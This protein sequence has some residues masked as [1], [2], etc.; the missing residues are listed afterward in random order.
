MP[1]HFRELEMSTQGAERSSTSSSA[2]H[3]ADDRTYDAQ[4]DRKLSYAV[5][6]MLVLLGILFALIVPGAILMLHGASGY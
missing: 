5:V 2:S 4:S 6:M 1:I 3:M